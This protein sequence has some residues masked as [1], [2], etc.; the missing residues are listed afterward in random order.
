MEKPEV[1]YKISLNINILSVVVH[2][3]SFAQCDESDSRCGAE[4]NKGQDHCQVHIRGI[5]DP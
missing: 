4:M 2:C 1:H 3:T 5:S